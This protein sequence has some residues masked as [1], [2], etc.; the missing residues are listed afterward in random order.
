MSKL[1]YLL[2]SDTANTLA[3][4][5]IRSRGQLEPLPANSGNSGRWEKWERMLFLQG[6]RRFG[7]GK[8]T[9]ISEMIS[10]RLERIIYNASFLRVQENSPPFSY[11]NQDCHASQ[12][13]WASCC[14]AHGRR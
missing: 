4:S 14:E 1:Q 13:A 8:W 9:K 12:V 2:P 3:Y 10:T 6:L 7:R 5:L 11:L